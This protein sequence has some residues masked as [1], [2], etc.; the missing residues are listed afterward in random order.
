M[1]K[2]FCPYTK[3]YFIVY[4][5]AHYRYTVI[6]FHHNHCRAQRRFQLYIIQKLMCPKLQ[7]YNEGKTLMI[8]KLVKKWQAVCSL[9]T[10]SPC[11][12]EETGPFLT[13]PTFSNFW[14]L[15]RTNLTF[16]IIVNLLAPVPPIILITFPPFYRL[17]ATWWSAHIERLW[18]PSSLP[19]I[20]SF[21]GVSFINASPGSTKGRERHTHNARDRKGEWK[22]GRWYTDF[23]LH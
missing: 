19:F 15:Q 1:Y 22:R 17:S 4:F 7:Y 6:N 3:V 2:E 13:T 16:L 14:H 21:W 8:K 10:T 20:S 5:Y 18:F 12:S 11:Q 9:S 23:Q